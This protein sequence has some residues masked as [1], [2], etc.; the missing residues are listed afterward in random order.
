M[1]EPGPQYAV[2]GRESAEEEARGPG[3]SRLPRRAWNLARRLLALERECHGRGRVEFVV[4]MVDGRWFLEVG[5][6][7]RWEA[8]EE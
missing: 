5:R 7:A 8:L 6:T 1:T 3:R 2:G 4:T